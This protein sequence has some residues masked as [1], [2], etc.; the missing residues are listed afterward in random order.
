M[1]RHAVSL[2]IFDLISFFS[3]E[4]FQYTRYPSLR[5]SFIMSAW[6][7][8]FL[9]R[10]YVSADNAKELFTSAIRKL[11]L[12]FQDIH[13][14]WFDDKEVSPCLIIIL[15]AIMHIMRKDCRDMNDSGAGGEGACIFQDRLWSPLHHWPFLTKRLFHAL[16]FSHI[17]QNKN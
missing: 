16:K 1:A 17:S 12:T 13:A 6:Y 7:F 14:R 2:L 4:E 10:E 8:I 9:F 3:D 5:H 11:L 15:W